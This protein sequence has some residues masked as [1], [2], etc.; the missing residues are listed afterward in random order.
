MIDTPPRD[1]LTNGLPLPYST[2][3]SVIDSVSGEEISKHAFFKLVLFTL[4]AKEYE[5][6]L[7]V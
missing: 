5:L 6:T 3:R 2:Y 4:L 1:L 7:S